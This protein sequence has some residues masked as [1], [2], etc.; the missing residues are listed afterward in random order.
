MN[1]PPVAAAP[2]IPAVQA[3][4]TITEMAQKLFFSA[5]NSAPV[6]WLDHWVTAQIDKL[7]EVPAQIA[8]AL[9]KVLPL[10]LL[11]LILPESIV[12]TCVVGA[13]LYTAISLSGI[14][15]SI[16]PESFGITYKHMA[17]VSQAFGF[18]SALQAIGN[19]LVMSFSTTPYMCLVAATIHTIA[20][21]ACFK[22][23]SLVNEKQ[24]R[25]TNAAAAADQKEFKNDGSAPITPG[26]PSDASGDV[27]RAAASVAAAS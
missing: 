19:T 26:G 7:P 3:N 18:F 24:K 8:K 12:Y 14:V 13:S 11:L 21:F 20:C 10:V 2:A 15:K 6:R 1:V 27:K 5:L 25:A 4:T 9:K 16:S 22:F 23:A 17:Y